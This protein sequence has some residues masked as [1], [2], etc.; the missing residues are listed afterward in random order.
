ME[1]QRCDHE[2]AMRMLTFDLKDRLCRHELRSRIIWPRRL[3]LTSNHLF[4]DRRINRPVAPAPRRARGV[5]NSL[6][7]DHD[8]YLQASA[9]VRDV[10]F[11][12]PRVC[13][14]MLRIKNKANEDVDLFH[15]AVANRIDA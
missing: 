7:A 11:D 6:R 4:D 2:H 15:F 1:V 5:S 8:P 12:G 13:A 14:K 3:E 9:A 10:R